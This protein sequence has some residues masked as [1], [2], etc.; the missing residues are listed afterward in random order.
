MDRSERFCKIDQMLAA[1]GVVSVDDFLAE[2]RISPA[3]F[4]RD[5]EYLRDRL[6]APIIWDR[7]S[8]GYRYQS[9]AQSGT[10]FALPGMWFNAS[11]AHALLLIQKLLKE[12]H[13]GL[14]SQ[15][16][17]PLQARL[18]ALLGSADHSAEEV[19]N[20]FRMLHATQRVLPFKHFE[21]IATATLG[22]KR[23][24]IQHFNR[25]RD[26]TLE[27]LI[28]PQQIVF[29][30]DNWYVDAWCHLRNCIRSFSID[31]ITGMESTDD[32]AKEIS[33][34]ELKEHFVKGYGIFSGTKLQWAKLKFSAARARWVANESWHPDQR[35]KFLD[36]GSYLLEVPYADDRELLMD[37]L[38][39]GNEVEIL[40]PALLRNRIKE[41]LASALN[42][43]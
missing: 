35:F 31:A 19:E 17:E 36:D 41:M 18:K 30:R 20:R 42:K 23:I 2:L 4:K 6:N 29:Y 9:K 3:T 14:L 38:K 8:G 21:A 7:D 32:T 11:E 22:R 34:I 40:S 16:I 15:H 43:Y 25:E 33:E 37:V 10:A 1:R 12:I 5:L 13:P 24:K 27:R 26:E 39:H 28:S